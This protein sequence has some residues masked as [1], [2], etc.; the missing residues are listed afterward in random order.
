MSIKRYKK[1]HATGAYVTTLHEK[2]NKPRR[3]SI[4][5][6]GDVHCITVMPNRTVHFHDHKNMEEMTTLVTFDILKNPEIGKSDLPTCLKT[7]RG[8]RTKLT[9]VCAGYSR[10]TVDNYVDELLT[11]NV[12]PST[13]RIH[14]ATLNNP[15]PW[16]EVV[17]NKFK[18][19]I[20]EHLIK[21]LKYY[22]MNGES[23]YRKFKMDFQWSMLRNF[24]PSAVMSLNKTNYDRELYLTITVS[25]Q[26]LINVWRKNRA[27]VGNV[28]IL[29][30]V[31]EYENGTT[32]C[33]A[34]KQ[35]HGF[36]IKPKLAVVDFNRQVVSWVNDEDRKNDLL[37]R[38]K[39]PRLRHTKKE[40]TK[41]V[42]D[43]V[44]K[45]K[46][47]ILIA[48]LLND[49]AQVVEDTEVEDVSFT[50]AP[51]TATNEICDECN[52]YMDECLCEEKE[53]D[54]TSTITT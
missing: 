27:V 12:A 37:H 43:L 11:L 22:G 48:K 47:E 6:G 28:L 39:T 2:M 23:S 17:L 9:T 19:E 13:P 10:N 1:S 5:C 32:L 46:R 35:S 34:G 36:K 26:W 7:L 38:D 45:E 16:R 52:E 51:V 42:E 49:N 4:E 18:K 15:K 50:S 31:K 24:T 25:P 44:G 29:Q 3:Y 40:L 41:I 14:Y 53:V 8:L 30:L 20:T 54:E 33:L 21:T